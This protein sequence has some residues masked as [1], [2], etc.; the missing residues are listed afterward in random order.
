M[1]SINQAWKSKFLFFLFYSFIAASL[2]SPVATENYIPGLADYVNHLATIIQA[3]MAFAEGQFPLRIAPLENLGYRYPIFQ[4]YSPTTY[5]L[6]GL[7]YQFI[8]P[9]NPLIAYKLTMWIG[10]L[11]GGIYMNRLVY[12]FV[13]SRPAAIL[14]SLAYLTSP[15]YIIVVNSF[16]DLSEVVALGILPAVIFYTLQRFYHP[17]DIKTLIKTSLCW[18]LLLTI[19]I[20]TFFYSSF[21]I[22]VLLL[23]VT[24]KNK[25][26]IKNLIHAGSAY[27]LALLLAMWYLGPVNLLGKY[28]II[29]TTMSDPMNFMM[30]KPVF[31][32]LIFPGAQRFQDELNYNHPSIGWVILMGFAVSVYAITNRLTINNKRANYWLPFFAVLFSIAFTM[33]WTP[34]NFWQWLPQIFYIGQYSWRLLGQVVWIGAIILAWGICWLF[35]NKLDLRHTII[36]MLLIVVST[37]A[38]FPTLKNSNIDPVEFLK[39]PFLIYNDTTYAINFLKNTQFVKHIDT[40]NINLL[41][42]NNKLQFNQTYSITR[43]LLDFAYKPVIEMNGEIPNDINQKQYMVALLNDKEI[44]RF[45]FKPGKFHWEIPF[46]FQEEI[47]N[48]PDKFYLQFKIENQSKDSPEPII[49]I[50]KLFISGFASPIDTMDVS[51]VETH[52]RLNKSITHCEL[53]VDQDIKVLE[54]PILYYPQLLQIKLNGKTVPYFGVM[55]GSNLLVGVTPKPSSLNKIDI[56]F[57]G[58]PWANLLSLMFWVIWGLLVLKVLIQI[59]S[60]KLSIKN[61]KLTEYIQNTKME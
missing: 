43:A 40:M 9:D 55:K 5:T 26:R 37:S 28:L 20:V 2:L 21:F 3:K 41:M 61:V 58:L 59:L 19:H 1:F 54:L 4:F 48:N 52:C 38:Y 23:M 36:G 32:N 35:K 39:K 42:E 53:N 45:A 18:Y 31:A 22:G 11:I 15:Y 44:S 16:A 49:A 57:R 24:F 51:K 12:W 27:G 34:F 13:K 10:L 46:P 30:L 60:S 14:A 8:T 25:K 50:E 7:I 47:F 33:T 56:K 29:N 17:S 6:A